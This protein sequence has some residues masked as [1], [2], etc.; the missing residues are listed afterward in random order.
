MD[1]AEVEKSAE[2][3]LELLFL[4]PDPDAKLRDVPLA[5]ELEGNLPDLPTRPSPN[6]PSRSV[7]NILLQTSTTGRRP[8]PRPVAKPLALR[9]KSEQDSLSQ[10]MTPESVRNHGALLP[11]PKP[12]GKPFALRSPPIKEDNEEAGVTIKVDEAEG[13]VEIVGETV[14]TEREKN[15]FETVPSDY[16]RPIM[17]KSISKPWGKF[18]TK[19]RLG[20]DQLSAAAQSS[21][22]LIRKKSTEVTAAIETVTKPGAKGLQKSAAEAG[23]KLKPVGNAVGSAIYKTVGRPIEQ[24]AKAIADDFSDNI[25]NIPFKNDYLCSQC[26][27]FPSI[28]VLTSAPPQDRRIWVSPLRRLIWHGKGCRFCMFLLRALSRSENDPFN[29]PQIRPF[30]RE[31][32]SE[33]TFASW[34]A[35][36]DASLLLNSLWP[37]GEG[38]RV[39]DLSNEDGAGDGATRLM[40]SIGASTINAGMNLAEVFLKVLILEENK[41][42][43][44]N[45]K[46]TPGKVKSTFAKSLHLKESLQCFVQIFTSA[47]SQGLL[48]ASLMGFGPSVPTLAALSS[49]RLRLETPLAPIPRSDPRPAHVNL[50]YGRHVRWGQIDAELCQSWLHHCETVHGSMCHEPAWARI[51]EKPTFLRVTDVHRLCLVEFGGNGV[52]QLRYVALSYV[53]GSTNNVRLERTKKV[54]WA[55]PQGLE[56]EMYQ[57]P[58]TILDAITVTKATGEKYL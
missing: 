1:L 55:Q 34:L 32:L 48:S 57:L 26:R 47:S 6:L 54:R 5:V 29:H 21:T 7:P 13:V 36:G 38:E 39:K 40:G 24:A 2:R 33:Q 46:Q 35:L 3:D 11:R 18:T 30:L 43:K 27:K 16:K 10:S 23:E 14:S 22:K 45:P 52:Q 9:S 25:I 44:P 42:R 49:F 28:Q 4:D 50:S 37:F 19:A 56:R 41:K 15:A 51:K 12:V 17:S 20:V 8:P 58:K 31:S 53:W